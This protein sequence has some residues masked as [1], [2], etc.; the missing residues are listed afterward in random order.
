MTLGQQAYPSPALAPEEGV[1][2][3]AAAWFI[4]LQ[5]SL[6]GQARRRW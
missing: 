1:E 5:S 2:T 3:E 4:R 6:E